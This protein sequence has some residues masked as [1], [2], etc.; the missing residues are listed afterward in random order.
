MSQK[1]GELGL[2]LENNLGTKTAVIV[3]TREEQTQLYQDGRGQQSYQEQQNSEQQQNKKQKETE[4]IDFLQ[5][6]RLGIRKESTS[7][8]Q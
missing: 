1:A 4:T 6:L 5:Q 2:I 7:I 8:W 3:E